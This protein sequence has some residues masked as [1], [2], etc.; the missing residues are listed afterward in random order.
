MAVQNSLAK[1]Q[2]K[3]TFSAYISGESMRNRINQIIGGKDGPRFITSIISAVSVNPTLSECEYGSIIS[4]AM[5]GESLKLSPSPQLGQYYMVPYD[6]KKTD[7]KKAQFQLGYKGYI[8]LALRSGEYA[9]IDALEIREGEYKGRDPQTGKYR[10]SFIEDDEER[11]SL[12][13]IG[14]MAYFEYLN[15]FRKVI[16][17]SKTKMEKH[18]D[19][20]SKAFSLAAYQKLQRG[21]I[22][23]SD[24]WK[25]SSYWYSDFDGMAFKTL[26]RNIISKWGIM[27]IE[28]QKAFE[29]DTAVINEDG[30]AQYVDEAPIYEEVT[31][32]EPASQAPA[33]DAEA[34]FFEN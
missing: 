29:S 17:W 8:Q 14:Y 18:A 21:E 13:I 28:M 27:S 15:G 23:K 10:F 32:S 2:E 22:P 26:L 5:L 31:A 24:M 20:Y 1:R 30:T 34:T 11:E 25:Y 12:P 33:T 19:T 6:N 3:T 16:Y 9:D 7:T 4:A